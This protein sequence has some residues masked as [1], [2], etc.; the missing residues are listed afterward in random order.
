[1]ASSIAVFDA[2]YDEQPW[3]YYPV[4]IIGAGPSGMQSMFDIS[5]GKADS[6]Q[7]SLLAVA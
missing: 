1:M 7:A 3:T 2:V 6:V 4:L 5:N